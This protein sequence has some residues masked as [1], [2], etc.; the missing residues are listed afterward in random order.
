MVLLSHRWTIA[1]LITTNG[2]PWSL[3][4]RHISDSVDGID[5]ADMIYYLMLIDKRQRP[6]FT[7]MPPPTVSPSHVLFRNILLANPSFGHAFCA[8]MQI[9][10]PPRQHV[11]IAQTWSTPQSELAE[12]AL[13]LHEVEPKTQVPRPSEVAT[14]KQPPAPQG[15]YLPHAEVAHLVTTGT[16]GSLH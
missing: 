7:Y 4:D 14:H 15:M 1:Y 13:L 12:Q 3:L 11:L 9:P 16:A 5:F 6:P 8:V 10:P 2:R